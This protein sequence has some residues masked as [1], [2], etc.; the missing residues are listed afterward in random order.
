MLRSLLVVALLLFSTLAQAQDLTPKI[1]TEARIEAEL[2]HETEV[3]YLDTQL[4]DVITDLELRHKINIEGDWEAI[5]AAA[6]QGAELPI[7]CSLK[8]V[9]LASA[10]SLILTPHKLTCVI[11]NEVLL[12]TSL[13]KE[14]KYATTKI[15]R[16]GDFASDLEALQTV[17]ETTIEY[18]TWRS[19]GGDIGSI[20]RYDDT[21]SLVVVHTLRTHRRVAWLINELRATKTD[22]KK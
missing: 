15:Y 13:E 3:Q 4:G 18:P 5:K 1:G 17:I 10:L 2:D 7:T 12:I 16:V 9:T 8:D 22:E 14:G 11:A 21:K 6:G 20:A 19:T